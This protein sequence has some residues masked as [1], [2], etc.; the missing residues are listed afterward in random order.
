MFS[1]ALPFKV[2]VAFQSMLVVLVGAVPEYH[3][4]QE[5]I[6]TS[7]EAFAQHVKFTSN[8][9]SIATEASTLCCYYC[10]Y[11]PCCFPEFQISSFTH[12][13]LI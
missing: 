8:F 12:M 11:V 13:A 7:R 6:P 1:F 5:E 10:I 2:Y 3:L 9:T 4:D